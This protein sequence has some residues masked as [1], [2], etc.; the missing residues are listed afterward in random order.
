MTTSERDEMKISQAKV[1]AV[2]CVQ[3]WVKKLVD[4]GATP[5]EINDIL[6][7]IKRMA[8]ISLGQRKG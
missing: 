3:E 6:E 5:N 4:L 1:S 7:Q 8:I 2:N